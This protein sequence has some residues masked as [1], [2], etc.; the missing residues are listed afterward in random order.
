MAFGRRQPAGA[1]PS[2]LR[3]VEDDALR[4]AVHEAVSVKPIG[5]APPDRRLVRL[6]I[7]DE[8]RLLAELIGKVAVVLASFIAVGDR[9]LSAVVRVVVGSPLD[10]GCLEGALHL[11]P[12]QV[13]PRGPANGQG[14]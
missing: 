7:V 5:V 8:N 4:T 2:C 1:N 10:R 6:V 11:L 3:F 12:A 9:G 14:R 13:T